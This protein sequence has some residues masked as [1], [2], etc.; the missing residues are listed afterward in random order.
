MGK[1][2]GQLE[3]LLELH[4]CEIVGYWVVEWTIA[5]HRIPFPPC[6]LIAPAWGWHVVERTRETE[7]TVG[8]IF[9]RT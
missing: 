4:H 6:G 7:P 8:R 9:L 2:V 1:R 3:L 5:N